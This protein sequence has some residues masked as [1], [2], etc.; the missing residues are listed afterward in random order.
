MQSPL[1][2]T[3]PGT[4]LLGPCAFRRSYSGSRPSLPLPKQAPLARHN[5][6]PLLSLL[7]PSPLPQPGFW[8]GCPSPSPQTVST[9]TSRDP[10]RHRDHQQLWSLPKGAFWVHV[11]PSPWS[12][13]HRSPTSPSD[14]RQLS[15]PPW[16]QPPLFSALKSTWPGPL[17]PPLP[18]LPCQG[19]HS[20][21]VL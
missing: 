8:K 18:G 17:L 21:V 16:A 19:L 1:R 2:H 9:A 10:H 3:A 4:Q 11:Y 14:L 20:H 5:P 12:F 13:L 6:H 15:G 7:A